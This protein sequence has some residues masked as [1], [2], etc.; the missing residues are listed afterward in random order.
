MKKI[1]LKAKISFVF[2]VLI[3]GLLLSG[4]EDY[5]AKA[6]DAGVKEEDAFKDFKS[7]QGFTE[8]LY[9][10]IVNPGLV[11]SN[12]D[13]NLADEFIYNISYYL[14]TRF[15]NGTYWDWQTLYGS[16]FQLTYGAN[17][18]PNNP[19]N[20]GLWPL[21]WYGIRKANLGLANMDKLVNATQEEK[22]IIKGQLLFFRG[23]FYHELMKAWGGMP[24]IEKVLLPTDEMKFPR[25]NYRETA[26]KAA[27]DLE[28]AAQLLPVKWDDTEVGKRTLGNNRQRISR[29]TAYAFLGK[30]LLYAASPLMNR[31][32][33]GSVN[34]E[35][36]L[37]KKAADA[38]AKVISLCEGTNPPYSLQ[39]WSKYTDLF[40]TVGNRIV[41]GGSEV[42]LTPPSY[43]NW[44][45]QYGMTYSLGQISPNTQNCGPTQNYVNN[46]GMANGLPITDPA[47]GYD[48]ADP[49]SNRDP[50]FYKTI[51]KDGDQL[52]ITTA[53]GVDRFAQLYTGGR[54][55]GNSANLSG[56]LTNKYWGLGCNKFD[57]QYASGQYVYTVPLMRLSD[58]Y[59]MYAEAVVQGYGT[60][61][62]SVSGNITAEDAINRVHNRA[63]L[64]NIDAKFTSAKEAFMGEIIRERAV[65]LSF[66]GFRWYDLR[67]WMLAG[68]T[69]YREK[70]AI[71]FDRGSNGKPINMTEKV[72]VTRVWEEKLYWLPLPVNQVYL[73]PEFGQNPGW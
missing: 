64:P 26:L 31:E 28:Q 14:G 1:V 37:S 62:S 5:L 61:K 10:C 23:Y 42:L 53:A 45:F 9:S 54:H 65:E 58:V 12:C 33:T 4:C 24:Y 35:E 50:R 16:Y 17:T 25:L 22:D 43:T 3:F 46:W 48:P 52:C 56:Y 19:S 49:W 30:N 6:P 41:P 66:E 2:L 72:L 39:P 27:T 21:C 71:Y 70:K 57:N 20:K 63:T 8:E 36:T 29:A 15:D 59:L 40:F 44:N 73:Y 47:S 51:V 11:S 7:F 13:F 32:S 38:F 60:P 18:A 67:R 69:I 68:Q 34:Y 55:R